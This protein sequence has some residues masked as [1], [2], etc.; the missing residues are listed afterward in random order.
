MNA[1]LDELA[2]KNRRVVGRLHEDSFCDDFTVVESLSAQARLSQT[3]CIDQLKHLIIK[4]RKYFYFSI[5][6]SHRIANNTLRF[7][8]N[9]MKE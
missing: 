8:S 3:A 1:Y 5:N 2:D 7:I 9:V 6:S 4:G